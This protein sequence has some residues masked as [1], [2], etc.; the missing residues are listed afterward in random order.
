MTQRSPRLLLVFWNVVF[1]GFEI[2]PQVV[3]LFVTVVTCDLG[4]VFFG[5]LGPALLKVILPTVAR[6]IFGYNFLV[7]GELLAPN[8]ADACE[9]L[10]LFIVVIFS[11]CLLVL[12]TT[13]V[14]VDLTGMRRLLSF[15]FLVVIFAFI[16]GLS[17]FLVMLSLLRLGTSTIQGPKMRKSLIFGAFV[18]P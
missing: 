10:V 4:E 3:P 12:T 13:S 14:S 17:L 11:I 16:V 9:Y 5:R 15:C 1:L 2:G 18:A 6:V 7:F 8:G